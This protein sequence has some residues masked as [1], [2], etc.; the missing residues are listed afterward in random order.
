M[1]TETQTNKP[2]TG[3]RFLKY[4]M[5]A[6]PV[7][8]PIRAAPTPGRFEGKMDLPIEID[9]QA[10]IFSIS[11]HNP[12]YQALEKAFGKAGPAWVGKSVRLVDGTG[13]KQVN[14]TPV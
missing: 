3:A 6:G 13:L 8:A 4:G 9:G 12:Q 14:V 5:L 11:S 7:V 1:P 10:F 2:G